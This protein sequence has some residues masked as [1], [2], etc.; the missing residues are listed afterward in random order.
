MPPIGGLRSETLIHHPPD[1]CE[2]E[3]RG[4]Q[5]RR[6]IAL[7]QSVGPASSSAGPVAGESAGLLSDPLESGFAAARTDVRS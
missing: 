3:A 7:E 2:A 4:Q 6:L 1:E 5:R